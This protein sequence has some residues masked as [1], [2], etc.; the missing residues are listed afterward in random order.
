MASIRPWLASDHPAHVTLKWT[1]SHSVALGD[2]PRL[3]KRLKMN[4]TT[5][6]EYICEPTL[7]CKI[8][9]RDID[10]LSAS[11]D[12]VDDRSVQLYN[13]PEL[14]DPEHYESMIM[15]SWIHLRKTLHT[16]KTLKIS[17]P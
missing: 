12:L 16:R 5:G 17:L 2:C 1:L 14:P 15:P 7:T 13:E 3:S 4:V 9:T 8:N 10:L 6:N 11:I